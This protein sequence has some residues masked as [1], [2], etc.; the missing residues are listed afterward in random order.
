MRVFFTVT[1]T[2]HGFGHAMGRTVNFL[3]GVGAAFLF[4]VP[5]IITSG[6]WLA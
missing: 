6:R 2:L 3:V 5:C 4:Y 1:W